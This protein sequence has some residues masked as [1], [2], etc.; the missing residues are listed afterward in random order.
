MSFQLKS[1]F[2]SDDVDP[3]CVEIL[4]ANG[5]QVVMD[6]KLRLEK[7]KFLAE[8]PVGRNLKYSVERSSCITK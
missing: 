7:E 4:K 5:V 6:T 3:Q 2:I 1:V 8:I